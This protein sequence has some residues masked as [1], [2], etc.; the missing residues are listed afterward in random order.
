MDWRKYFTVAVDFE[1]EK[2]NPYHDLKGRFAR[3]GQFGL[4]TV[5]LA[6]VTQ[7]FSSLPS[8]ERMRLVRS[9]IRSTPSGGNGGASANS[10]MFALGQ[11]TGQRPDKELA[12]GLAK[13]LGELQKRGLI[14]VKLTE[15][16]VMD[17][18]GR[19]MLKPDNQ[20]TLKVNPKTGAVSIDFEASKV[21]AQSYTFENVGV[22]GATKYNLQH[23][24]EITRGARYDPIKG[25]P[26][27]TMVNMRAKEFNE[28]ASRTATMGRYFSTDKR[29]PENTH[30]VS[31]SDVTRTQAL[32]KASK[33]NLD[34][35]IISGDKA[36][37]SKA[38]QEYKN[39]AH[40]AAVKQAI[41]TSNKI[42]RAAEYKNSQF[43]D[44]TSSVNGIIGTM[45]GNKSMLQNSRLQSF[46]EDSFPYTKALEKVGVKAG[47]A[48]K[49]YYANTFMNAKT[50]KGLSE[51]D[52]K[53]FGS[54]LGNDKEAMKASIKEAS[55]ALFTPGTYG[56]KINDAEYI[57]KTGPNAGKKM[58][59][60]GGAAN[61]AKILRDAGMSH[62]DA[63][64]TAKK[65]AQNFQASPIQAF[66]GSFRKLIS[67]APEGFVYTNPMSGYRM[68]FDKAKAT[69]TKIKPD[70]KKYQAA[71]HVSASLKVDGKVRDVSIP[72]ALPYRNT[73]KTGSG[74]AALFIQNWDAA[75][76]SSV[77][78]QMKTAK[79]LHDAI[80]IS[81]DP[82]AA[83][84]LHAS[85]AG[86][87]NRVAKLRPVDD[88]ARQIKVFTLQQYKANHPKMSQK[89]RKN[90]LK[91][92]RAI[93][94]AQRNFRNAMYLPNQGPGIVNVPN[95]N[96]HF[97]EE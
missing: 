51:S 88:L 47:D 90:L 46:S 52:F 8:A 19:A 61:A 37:I 33:R 55:K 80:A 63:H 89:E 59:V 15:H 69:E 30:T 25:S 21:K 49:P 57:L 87:Y 53:G 60:S 29:A 66:N 83:T 17:E 54:S 23:T 20:R 84:R 92:I 58:L 40:A 56:S 41:F 9:A 24:G 5:N 2:A 64:N 62:D 73:A 11:L 94:A 77:G 48:H 7:P 95:D 43:Y 31:L 82:R 85:V 97:V 81:K 44:A 68:T 91:K 4:K 79:T 67:T 12:G 35:A 70:G 36:A 75:V 22:S 39:A 65:M 10:L 96:G 16:D 32:A 74:A 28:G 34:S 71:L 76:I 1:V 18:N 14:K 78:I 72:Y 42:S 3:R 93:N 50:G 38:T 86:A 26:A 13:T 6:G 45:V 27:E